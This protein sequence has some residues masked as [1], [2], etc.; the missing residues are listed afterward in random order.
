MG[1]Y[2]GNGINDVFHSQLGDLL[3]VSDKTTSRLGDCYSLGLAATTLH[4]PRERFLIQPGRFIS[5]VGQLTE[6]YTVL[7]G[8]NDSDLLCTYNAELKKSLDAGRKRFHGHYGSRLSKMSQ[9]DLV[10][11][12]LK[13]KPD[14]R[15]AVMGIW[16][17]GRDVANETA[18][19]VPCNVMVVCRI[20]KSRKDQR[21][22]CPSGLDELHLTVFNRSNDFFLGWSSV[23]VV[24]FSFLQEYIASH[25]PVGVGDLNFCTSDMHYYKD[26]WDKSSLRKACEEMVSRRSVSFEKGETPY[27]PY[28]FLDTI[29]LD[30]DDIG[31]IS[32]NNWEYKTRE[33]YWKNPKGFCFDTDNLRGVL[34]DII[35]SSKS[36]RTL[37]KW[38]LISWGLFWYL[39]SLDNRLY[40]CSVREE[41]LWQFE[42][43]MLVNFFEDI[44]GHNEKPL[45][46]YV[47]LL[48]WVVRYL[49]NRGRDIDVLI[50]YV[51][52]TMVIEGIGSW[53]VWLP[54]YILCRDLQIKEESK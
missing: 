53:G 15:R 19:D 51:E 25:I 42:M 1:H 16:N 39:K 47:L 36:N 14:T 46:I 34:G 12:Q 43:K 41:K 26:W 24:Q 32:G 7:A 13:E 45:D 2:E 23:N 40:D 49:S 52:E 18:K 9:I 31:L 27:P 8:L 44:R 10:I 38:L 50:E 29:I 17:V 54:N 4:K 5:P 35:L 22:D 33:S 30:K 11:E 21:L 3:N 48:R 28:D 20:K 37:D 6:A